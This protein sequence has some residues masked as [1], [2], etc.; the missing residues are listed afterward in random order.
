MCLRIRLRKVH[1]RDVDCS[2][3]I[4]IQGIPE[5]IEIVSGNKDNSMPF[6]NGTCIG[7]FWLLAQAGMP[8]TA[9]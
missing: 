1:V 8:K 4:K 6:H 2:S 3:F 7:E 5:P 9:L